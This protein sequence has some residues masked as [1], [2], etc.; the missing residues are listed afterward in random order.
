M[1][2]PTVGR[3]VHYHDP[4]LSDQPLD[5]HIAYV[6]SERLINI[7]GFD[8]NGVPFSETSV[9]LVQPGDEVPDHPHATWMPY[10]VK[11]DHGSES[12]ER[13][14]GEQAV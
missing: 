9:T 12:G 3:V 1:I 5:A 2:Q 11:K 4:S 8:A 10:Q 13:A 7:G 6:H 14:A